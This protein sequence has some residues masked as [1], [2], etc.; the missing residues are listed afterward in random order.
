MTNPEAAVIPNP[1]LCLIKRK[2]GHYIP[3]P[4]HAVPS[5]SPMYIIPSQLYQWNNK[6]FFGI[7]SY[8]P[9]LPVLSNK[10]NEVTLARSNGSMASQLK[11]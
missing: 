8:L 5:I 6:L 7:E 3:Y 11:L 2:T 1:T 4:A 9:V 10:A